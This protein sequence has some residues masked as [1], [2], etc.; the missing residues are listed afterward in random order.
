MT[1]ICC[2]HILYWILYLTRKGKE[3]DEFQREGIGAG[4]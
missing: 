3:L 4:G 2:V 1:N